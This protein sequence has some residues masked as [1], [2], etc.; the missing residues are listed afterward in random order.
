MNHHFWKRTVIELVIIFILSLTPLLWFRPGQIMVGH[1]NTYPLEAKPFLQNRLSTW[2]HNFFGHDQSLIMGTIPI[3]AL[4]SLPTI[5]GADRISGQKIVYVIWFFMIGVSAYVLSSVLAPSSRVFKLISVLFYQFN[6]FILQ[7]WWIGEKSKFSAY[8]AQPIIIALSILVAR[9]SISVLSGSILVSFT[10]FF[11]NAGGL[12]GIPLY[13]GL[14]VV[15]GCFVVWTLIAAILR[16]QWGALGRMF[17]FFLLS[18]VLTIGINAYYILPAVAKIRSGNSP[19]LSQI[20][21]SSGALSWADQIS[22]SASFINLMR[23][24]GIP[25]WYDNPDH[26]FSRDYLTNPILIGASFLFSILVFAGFLTARKRG[27]SKSWVGLFFLVYLVGIFFTAGTHPPLGFIYQM[28]VERI[29]GFFIFRSPFYKFAGSIM[30]AQAFLTGALV[31]SLSAKWRKIIGVSIGIGLLIYSAP[32]FKG[33][34]FQW[35]EG[36]STRLTVPD[37]VFSFGQWLEQNKNARVLMVPPNS[38]TFGYSLYNWGYLSFQA[39]PTLVSKNSMIINNDQINQSERDLVET[40]YVAIA[41]GNRAR[42]EKLIRLLGITHVLVAHDTVTDV[43]SILPLAASTYEQGLLTSGYFR[44]QT[45]F[46]QW[47]LY[48]NIDST[49]SKFVL[50]EGLDVV[51]SPMSEVSAFIDHLGEEALFISDDNFYDSKNPPII[52]PTCAN[53]PSAARPIIVFPTRPILPGDPFYPVLTFLG[54]FKDKPK[55]PKSAI[56]ALLGM[57][58][59]QTAEFKELVIAQ[60]RI[61]PDLVETYRSTLNKIIERFNDLSTMKDRILVS[62]DITEYLRQELNYLRP[63]LGTYLLGGENATLVGEI[64][65]SISVAETK[66]KSYS[67]LYGAINTRLYEFTT[68]Y[69]ANYQFFINTADLISKKDESVPILMTIDGKESKLPDTLNLQ[70]GSHDINLAFPEI[71]DQTLVLEPIET[72]FSIPGET[73]CFGVVVKDI[74]GGTLH[75]LNIL[76]TNNYSDQLLLYVWEIS[77]NRKH[78]AVA[79]RLGPSEFAEEIKEAW[80]VNP[81]TQE[82]TIAAC[83]DKITQERASGYLSLSLSRLLYPR[84]VLIPENQAVVSKSQEINIQ[85]LSPTRYQV[86]LPD[87]SGEKVLVF[88]ERYDPWW[89]IKGVAAKHILINGFANGWIISDPKGQTIELFYRGDTYFRWGIY[90]SGGVLLISFAVLWRKRKTYADR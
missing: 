28:F 42:M 26:P 11:F 17:S 86:K 88:Y 54:R 7:G 41:N 5:L 6:F 52:A 90:I 10:M 22:A 49:R 77:E 51:G 74:T 55:E 71:S 43:E 79:H 30:F 37:Y 1:D 80:T 15:V 8:I 56:Y 44:K 62:R 27:T 18:F 84:I 73:S 4:D 60:K 47:V 20:G 82:L 34:F 24:Q 61:T 16:K 58:I 75:Q 21:G 63:T 36:F 29:P 12:Y 3:H 48:E 35:R 33:N 72:D 59:K 45:Q 64:V 46:G 65:E 89:E 67:Q 9:G 53:C 32:F 13:G 78:L 25:D 14:M 70:A 81:Q 39:L 69:G 19:V 68:K 57:T 2:S 85:D 83:A 31:D 23:L 38:P 76:Y 66:L 87:G 50:A 40:L